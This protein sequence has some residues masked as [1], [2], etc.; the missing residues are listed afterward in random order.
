MLRSIEQVARDQE[1]RD[2]ESYMRTINALIM[3]AM[4]GALIETEAN[5]SRAVGREAAG[6]AVS[7]IPIVG[8]VIGPA[9][10]IAEALHQRAEERGN[11]IYALMTLRRG[12]AGT[13]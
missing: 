7:L 12:S 8:P 9:I 2:A 4:A 11:G 6:V 3:D 13:Q 5:L 1:H 10:G